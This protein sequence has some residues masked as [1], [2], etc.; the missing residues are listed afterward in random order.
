MPVE[1]IP[2]VGRPFLTFFP[3]ESKATSTVVEGM[4][5]ELKVQQAVR[6][7]LVLKPKTAFCVKYFRNQRCL[8]VRVLCI[9]G[10]VSKRAMVNRG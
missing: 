7:W 6:S 5:S 10:V 1:F 8:T 4:Y 9:I 2:S 3:V